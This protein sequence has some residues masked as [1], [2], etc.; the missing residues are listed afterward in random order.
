MSWIGWDL[1]ITESEG[2][3]DGA[4]RMTLVIEKDKGV[5]ACPWHQ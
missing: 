3:T 1:N 5:F 4:I 2:A